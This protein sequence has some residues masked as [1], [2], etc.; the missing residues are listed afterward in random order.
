MAPSDA[1]LHVDEVSKRFGDFTAVEDL[2]FEV[3]AGRVFGFLGPNGAGKTSTIRM[4]VGI[5]A[6]DTDPASGSLF[7]SP[8]VPPPP[9]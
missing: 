7:Q 6:P 9:A 5:T 8:P 2:S 4:I 1:T 3:R